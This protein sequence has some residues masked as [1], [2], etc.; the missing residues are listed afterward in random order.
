VEQVEIINE[1]T[2]T[3]YPKVEPR[4][5]DTSLKYINSCLGLKLTAQ[6]ALTLLKKMSL[7]GEA[8]DEDTL[9][10]DVPI[11]RSGNL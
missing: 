7:V 10:I 2:K 1:E 5:V 11:S 6:E 4:K 8:V 9:R 3:L